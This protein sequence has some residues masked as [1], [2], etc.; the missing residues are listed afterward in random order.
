MLKNDLKNDIEKTLQAHCPEPPEGFAERMDKKAI[1]LI[2]KKHNQN[3]NKVKS[4]FRLP[5]LAAAAVL[6]L[7]FVT[8]T[9]RDLIIRPDEIRA[10]ETTTPLVTAMSEGHGEVTEGAGLSPEAIKTLEATYPG[11]INELKPVNLSNEQQGVRFDLVSAVIKNRDFY[12]VYAIQDLEGD[13]VKAN[14]STDYHDH[15]GAD[16]HPQDIM[17]LNYDEA[18][19]KG[20]YVRKYKM[21]EAIHTTGEVVVMSFQD[22]WTSEHG[23]VDLLP[24]LEQYGKTEKSVA[25]PED[26][27]I[28]PYDPRDTSANYSCVLDYTQ[29]LDETLYGPVK[30]TGIGWIDNKLH[31]QVYNQ[32]TS[33][34]SIGRD[35]SPSWKIWLGSHITDQEGN[36]FVD[37]N[38]LSWGYSDEKEPVWHEYVWDISPDEK[39]QMDLSVAVEHI[40]KTLEAKWEFRVPVDS[41]VAGNS[42]KPSANIQNES[43]KQIEATLWG[44]FIDWIAQ[45]TESLLA[46]CADEWK[47]DR[48]DPTQA[49]QKIMGYWGQPGGYKING[50]SGKDNDPVRTVD[51]TVQ[52][53][54]EDGG[55]SYNRHEIAFRLQQVTPAVEAYRMDPVGFNT[56]IDVETVPGKELVLLTEEEIIRKAISY[57]DLSYDDF[58]PLNLSVEKQGIRMEVISG[59]VK[60]QELYVLCS[61]QD[62]EGRYD[63]LNMELVQWYRDEFPRMDY[64]R[65]YSN[66]A[67][68]KSFWLFHTEQF[69]QYQAEDGTIALVIDLVKFENDISVD[70]IPFLEKYGKES[71]GVNAPENARSFADGESTEGLKVLDGA[72]TE[73]EYAICVNLE[74]TELLDKINAALKELIEDGTVAS[75]IAKYIPAE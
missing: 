33:V 71:E 48:L 7:C 60:G 75:I 12:I 59:C 26:L 4:R 22:L 47:N 16:D 29:P 2:Q 53:K 51:L 68:N 57:P 55:Y 6:A 56:G 45:D 58:I 3:V 15:F 9:T 24:L 69:A 67:E 17:R 14:L 49:I 72:Y 39:S 30:L 43:D 36:R 25:L 63:G 35:Y 8:A 42:V 5:V 54:T 21:P 61:L 38:T 34:I 19:H 11:L 31:V 28:Q 64:S 66:Y 50:I 41:I 32:D 20:E 10:R 74:N 37:Y 44:F 73:E 62:L 13:R 65:P 46:L 23:T 52:W 1:S 40:T 18:E 27:N 70:L